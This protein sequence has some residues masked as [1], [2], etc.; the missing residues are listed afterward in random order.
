MNRHADPRQQRHWDARAAGNFIGGGAGCGLLLFTTLAGAQG[1]LRQ[2]LV[3][4]ALLLVAAG[5]LCVW[6][7]IGRPWRA[8]NVF[9]HP[10]TSWMSREAALAPPLLACGAAAL[11]WPVLQPL[12]ALLAAAFLYCQAR[13]LQAAHG[14]PA[15][16]EPLT[17]PLLVATGVT[18]GAGLYWLAAPAWGAGSMAAWI[19]FGAL[20]ALRFAIGARW[21]RR[22]AGNLPAAALRAVDR[23]GHGYNAGSLLPLALVAVVLAAPLSPPLQGLLQALAGGLAAAGGMLFKFMLVTRAGFK[24]GFA[25]PHLP[26]R[27]RH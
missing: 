27:G 10:Q 13:I 26:V 11:A 4:A 18:E 6:A 24:Q 7:E 21:Y 22:L 15:W 12:A 5:L 8:L 3:A 1:S 17:V 16:R 14:I 25:L 2:G 19:A 9:L 20:L 23:A